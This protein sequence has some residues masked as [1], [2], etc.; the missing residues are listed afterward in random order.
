[1]SQSGRDRQLGFNTKTS[2][3]LRL[4]R[5]SVGQGQT[6]R[7]GHHTTR[8][9]C[10]IDRPTDVCCCRAERGRQA[11]APRLCFARSLCPDV[12]PE[13]AEHAHAPSIGFLNL[14]ATDAAC[15][16]V[17]YFSLGRRVYFIQ[18][19]TRKSSVSVIHR[20]CASVVSQRR[21]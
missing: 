7:T 3:A 2:A 8:S 18:S 6:A 15:V 20:A 16:P 10:R 11:R 13:R 1:M 14:S 12:E 5:R 21:R 4:G 19:V 9:S 17:P